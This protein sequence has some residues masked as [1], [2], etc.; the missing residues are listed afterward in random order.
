L[1]SPYFAAI[2]RKLELSKNMRVNLS[3]LVSG[4]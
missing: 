2:E 4:S 1:R 3:E